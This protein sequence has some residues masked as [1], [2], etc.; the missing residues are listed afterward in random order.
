MKK[1]FS[2]FL[3][4][5]ASVAAFSQAHSGDPKLTELWDPVPSIIQPGKTAQDAP[6]DAIVLFNGKDFSA[7]N[8]NKGPVQWTLEDNAM[9][10]K[11]GSGGI[12]TKKGFGDCQLH[13]EWRTP[14][15]VKGD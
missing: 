6:S 5:T 9:T 14:S 1:F 2:T 4:L 11:R 13:I 15:V 12:T 8:G 3:A 7:W 10:V